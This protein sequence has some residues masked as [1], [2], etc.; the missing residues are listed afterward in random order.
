[1][2]QFASPWQWKCGIAAECRRL[3]CYID[4]SKSIRS[5]TA[6]ARKERLPFARRTL[7]LV[8][9]CQA[10]VKPVEQ[11]PLMLMLESR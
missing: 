6:A 11:V 10:L 3:Y 5:Q 1:M 7:L 8:I 4:D 9:W 2:N